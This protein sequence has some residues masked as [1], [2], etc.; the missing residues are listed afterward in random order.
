LVIDLDQVHGACDFL[1]CAAKGNL[2][3]CILRCC[4]GNCL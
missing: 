3:R 2:H 4:V 1:R